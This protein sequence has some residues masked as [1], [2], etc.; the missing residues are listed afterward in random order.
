M[1][2]KLCIRG[3]FCIGVCWGGG[4]GALF[5]YFKHFFTLCARFSLMQELLFPR[6]T[7]ALGTLCT[8]GDV[9]NDCLFAFDRPTVSSQLS[10]K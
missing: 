6:S 10:G 3:G 4:G 9:I 1:H 2:P 7:F 5:Q 8:S